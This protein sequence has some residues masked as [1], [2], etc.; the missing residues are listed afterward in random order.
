MK[1]ERM[2]RL[3][4]SDFVCE[5]K[6]TLLSLN[7]GIMNKSI[8]S[9]RHRSPV[10]KGSLGRRA[11]G[12]VSKRQW[13]EAAL[14]MLAAEGVGSVKITALAK[15][16]NISKSG[17]YWHFK[18]REDLLEEMKA[19]WADEFSKKII[20]EILKQK[21]S[22]EENLLSTVELVR[23][24]QGSKFDLA[25]TAWAQSDPLVREL[26][27]KVRDMRISFVRNLLASTGYT[28]ADLEARARLFVVYFSWSEVM[29]REK[30][31]GLEGEPLDEILNILI[32]R[33]S[34]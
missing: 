3:R 8:S 22:P 1:L 16:L 23:N 18:D 9:T 11:T 17:F 30:P 21:R 26:V 31:A 4:D 19:Y 7:C 27:D 2:D 25:F 33:T 12:R 15:A 5:T 34:S 13:L 24:Q 14:A 6:I 29:Y 10:Q 28:G 20:S 32:R